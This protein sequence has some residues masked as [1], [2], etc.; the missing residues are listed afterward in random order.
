MRTATCSLSRKN[1]CNSCRISSPPKSSTGIFRLH[2]RQWYLGESVRAYILPPHWHQMRLPNGFIGT[3]P[4]F[5]HFFNYSSMIRFTW[6]HRSSGHDGLAFGLAPFFLRLLRPCPRASFADAVEIIDALGAGAGKHP[7]DG[8]YHGTYGLRG[9]G[10]RRRSTIWPPCLCAGIAE[11]I[12]TSS[13]GRGLHRAELT[14][15]GLSIGS[16]MAL[17]H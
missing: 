3:L 9:C 8:E 6:F 2:F 13:A 14:A 16:R 17:G 12:H 5:F 1:A 11:T 7:R 4:G 15:S 10:G